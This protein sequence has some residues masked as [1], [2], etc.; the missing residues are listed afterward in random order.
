V[1]K[2]ERL[3]VEQGEK[4]SRVLLH[5]IG[6]LDFDINLSR[7][8]FCRISMSAWGRGYFRAEFLY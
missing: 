8:A 2:V 4:L 6:I 1:E 5:S 3:K 7:A